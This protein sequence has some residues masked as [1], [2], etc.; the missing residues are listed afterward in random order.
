LKTSLFQLP[1]FSEHGHI[2]GGRKS[3]S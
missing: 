2:S 1:F 3:V